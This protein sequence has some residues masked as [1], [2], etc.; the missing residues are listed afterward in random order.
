MSDDDISPV[1]RWLGT[2][3]PPP[4]DPGLPNRTK[5]ALAHPVL[6]GILTG[7]VMLFVGW[8]NGFWPSVNIAVALVAGLLNWFLWTS[9]GGPLRK[10]YGPPS[11][12]DPVSHRNE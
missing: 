2:P 5:W 9:H 3:D 12:S 1:D 4:R 10:R 8:F 11:D 7:A 6:L